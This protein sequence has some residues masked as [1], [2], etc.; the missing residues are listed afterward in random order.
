MAAGLGILIENDEKII[1]KA[2]RIYYKNICFAEDEHKHGFLNK[3]NAFI[4]F[5]KSDP[6]EDKYFLDKEF[7]KCGIKC[8]KDSLKKGLTMDMI[9]G[10]T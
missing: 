10:S 4:D 9:N 1:K 6:N 8:R 5:L 3:N 2:K 7:K